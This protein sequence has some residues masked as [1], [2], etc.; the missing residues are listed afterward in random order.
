MTP[1]EL[2]LI[3]EVYNEKRKYEREDKLSLI[4]I[5]ENLHRAK[6][7]PTLEKLI[8]KEETPVKKHMSDDEMLEMV[9]QLNAKFGG[10]VE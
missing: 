6:K 9:K 2:D 3:S 7:L 10:I 4:W 8:G 1:H 5:S